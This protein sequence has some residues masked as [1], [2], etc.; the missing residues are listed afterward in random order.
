MSPINNHLL[1]TS[2]RELVMGVGVGV[3]VVTL[4][5]LL[6]PQ[7]GIF[8][9][10]FASLFLSAVVW[11]IRSMQSNNILFLSLYPTH[12]HTTTTPTCTMVQETGDS[13]AIQQQQQQQPSYM[14]APYSLPSPY[15]SQSNPAVVMP[16]QQGPY[17]QYPASYPNNGY[18]FDSNLSS[19]SRRS[20][21]Y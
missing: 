8:S 3:V 6:R 10:A 17:Q 12:H 4:D 19:S 20:S 5:C 13:T 2:N 9:S 11:Y 18:V 15:A 14:A 1:R 21:F 7:V 16:Q